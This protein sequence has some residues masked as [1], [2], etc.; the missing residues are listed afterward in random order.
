MTG[1]QGG[2]VIA[3]L[4]QTA[5]GGNTMYYD[6]GTG[7]IYCGGSSETI[8][9]TIENLTMNTSMI[10]NLQPRTY[11]YNSDPESGLQVGYIAEE[12]ETIT[13]HFATYNRPKGKPVNINYNSILVFL[14]EEVKKLKRDNTDLMTRILNLENKNL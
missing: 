8:K 10:D 2:C 11:Y 4:R 3:P 1:I 13:T 7:E 9:N 6:T 5:P 12:V 14:V